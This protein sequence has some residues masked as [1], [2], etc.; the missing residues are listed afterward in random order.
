MPAQKTLSVTALHFIHTSA[1]PT[2][3][4]G[5]ICYHMLMSIVMEPATY[6]ILNSCTFHCNVL[7]NQFANARGVHEPGTTYILEP[8]ESDSARLPADFSQKT[9]LHKYNNGCHNKL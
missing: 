3:S 1:V 5:F 7:H 2:A 6:I 4:A 9:T 8:L